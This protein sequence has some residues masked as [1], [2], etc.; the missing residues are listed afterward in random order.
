MSG[1]EWWGI[2]NDEQ[3]VV[4]PESYRGMN[5]FLF[6]YYFFTTPP[7]AWMLTR[8]SLAYFHLP[9][10]VWTN[11]CLPIVWWKTIN[12]R[13]IIFQCVD[14]TTTPPPHCR[15]R[16]RV[17]SRSFGLNKKKLERFSSEITFQT[18][19]PKIDLLSAKG[20]DELYKLISTRTSF[21]ILQNLFL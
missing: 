6:M 7:W 13:L 11:S 19:R 17:T 15:S 9:G 4:L 14:V 3:Y 8:T 10:S 2:V 16:S 18:S 20:V 1:T 5:W 12:D 21:W